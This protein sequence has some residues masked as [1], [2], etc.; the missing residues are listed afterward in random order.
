[1]IKEYTE[2]QLKSLIADVEKEFTSHLAKAEESFKLAKSEDAPKKDGLRKRTRRKPLKNPMANLKSRWNLKSLKIKALKTNISK[3][4]SKDPA[5]GDK[6]ESKEERM[7]ED[8]KENAK[9]SDDAHGEAQDHG[10]DDE[11]MDH[12]HSMYSSMSKPEL[13]A[14]HDA[15][16]KC[17]DS[18]GLAKC[19]DGMAKAEMA[20]LPKMPKDIVQMAVLKMAKRRNLKPQLQ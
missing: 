8:K 6:P 7:G 2:E 15:I 14:H 10:Y 19:E 5:K 17:M 16:R 9:P 4:M 18:M 1:M 20:M 12:M 3:T 11:D 13:K